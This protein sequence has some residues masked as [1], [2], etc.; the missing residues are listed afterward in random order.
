MNQQEQNLESLLV[1]WNS[2][3][4]SYG[5][6]KNFA[7]DTYIALAENPENSGDI[8]IRIVV[9]P[10]FMRRREYMGNLEKPK[11]KCFLCDNAEQ[12]KIEGSNLVV[13]FDFMQDYIFVPNRFPIF[14]GHFLLISKDHDPSQKK[15]D[16]VL[17]ENYLETIAAIS[18]KYGLV[19]FRNHANAG[20]SL[21]DHEHTHFWPE[22]VQTDGEEKI[23]T[24]PLMESCLES[25]I[26]AEDIYRVQSS[27]FDTLV[28]TGKNKT[29]Q[30][31]GAARELEKKEIIFTF[32]YASTPGAFFLTPHKRKDEKNQIS[33]SHPSYIYPVGEKTPFSYS[34]HM[35]FLKKHI[36]CRGEFPWEDFLDFKKS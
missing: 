19:A 18:N 7:D 28:F 26:F 12:A 22:S 13:P 25:S 23:T 1:H 34:A 32:C 2:A 10:G 29:C 20:M 35:D 31:L 36:Y 8:P 30:L 33:S 4:E 5:T 24:F 27:V 17:T 21:P 15:C 3:L 11:G 14:R 16:S 6:P 9:A